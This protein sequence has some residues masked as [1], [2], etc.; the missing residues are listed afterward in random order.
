[1]NTSCRLIVCM[2]L[3]TEMVIVGYNEKHFHNWIRQI[4]NWIRYVPSLCLDIFGRIVYVHAVSS[5]TVFFC[6]DVYCFATWFFSVMYSIHIEVYLLAND[7]NLSS[8]MAS[9]GIEKM[10][11][12]VNSTE[13]SYSNLKLILTSTFTM[14]CVTKEME[15]YVWGSRNSWGSK[16]LSSIIRV[17][18]IVLVERK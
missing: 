15:I 6:C 11:T 7:D 4:H 14:E 1:M 17:L 18:T 5:N 13:P 12:T 16:G 3:S 8:L 9:S 10:K 2:T